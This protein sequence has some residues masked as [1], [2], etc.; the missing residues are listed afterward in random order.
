MSVFETHTIHTS[1][2]SILVRLFEAAST[3]ACRSRTIHTHTHRCAGLPWQYGEIKKKRAH[4]KLSERRRVL[5]FLLT[6]CKAKQSEPKRSKTMQG[7][8]EEEE[9]EEGSANEGEGKG[10][11]SPAVPERYTD[12]HGRRR[13]Y[14]PRQSKR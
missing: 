3:Q 2:R 11:R 7:E 5:S 4:L 13:R 12:I 10:R 1:A 8:E 9:E 6:E 14:V